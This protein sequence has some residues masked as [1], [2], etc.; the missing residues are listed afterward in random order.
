M[1][2]EHTYGFNRDD[3]S[4]L[5]QSIGTETRLY[6]EFSPRGFGGLRTVVLDTA[7]AAATN[8]LSAEATATASV[9]SK[10]S[11]GDLVDSGNNI[12]VVNRFENIDLDQYTLCAVARIDGEWR[13]ISADCSPLASWP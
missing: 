1:T 8:A 9:L 7:I 3:A 6:R 12:T 11:S 13:I 4:A 5:L 2:D 10:N